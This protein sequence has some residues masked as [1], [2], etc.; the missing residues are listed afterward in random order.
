MSHLPDTD[1]YEDEGLQDGPPQ[2]PLVGALTGLPEALLSP[3][4]GGK[5]DK[6]PE[7]PGP[8]LGHWNHWVPSP[9][10]APGPTNFAP[11]PF[12]SV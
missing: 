8:H 10:D 3:L 5:T 2:H 6:K 4:W 7:L 12:A 9:E 11:V 1:G